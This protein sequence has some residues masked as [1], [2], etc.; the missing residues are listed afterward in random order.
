MNKRYIIQ[1]DEHYINQENDLINDRSIINN[2][3]TLYR[4]CIINERYILNS[5]VHYIY[6]MNFINR[7]PYIINKH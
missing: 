1:N 3:H 6:S 4:I 7:S 5:D 2:V